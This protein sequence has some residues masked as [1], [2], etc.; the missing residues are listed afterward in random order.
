MGK[1]VTRRQFLQAMA[2]V[3]GVAVAADAASAQE[4]ETTTVDMTDD[5]VFDPETVTVPP[6]TTV[7][8]DNVGNVGHTVTAYE[9]EIPDEAEY[10]A[11]GGFD[12]E[13]AARSGYPDQGNI[14]GGETYEHTFETEGS[15][16]YFCIPHE[17]TGMVGTVEVAEGG[18]GDGGGSVSILPESAKTLVVA[19]TSAMVAILGF[20]WVFMK[21]GGEYGD[22]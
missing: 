8:W 5:L 13:E 14:P 19:A 9:D 22:Q 18:G 17:G 6:G 21:Y 1:N 11:S 7:V 15:F 20:A 2:G 12:S 3:G 4:G 16:G 10:F